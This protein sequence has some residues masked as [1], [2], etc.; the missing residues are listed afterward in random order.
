MLFGQFVERVFGAV[1]GGVGFVSAKLKFGVRTEAA[2]VTKSALPLALEADFEAVE[3]GYDG[4]ADGEFGVGEA[5]PGGRID[6]GVGG[7]EFLGLNLNGVVNGGGF[8]VPDAAHAPIGV[9]HGF[10][11][12]EFGGAGGPEPVQIVGADGAEEAV[13]FVAED[14]GAFGIESMTD[15]IP[16][17]FRFSLGGFRPGGMLGVGLIRGDFLL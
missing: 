16:G 3:A 1:F 8:D 12:E 17:C 13:L 2:E 10:D 5:G 4:G 9:D 15:G 6:A 11:V 14:D 7:G